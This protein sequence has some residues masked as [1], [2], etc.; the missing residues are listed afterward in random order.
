MNAMFC[1][2]SKGVA[3]MKQ[4]CHILLHGAQDVRL[5]AVDA[6]CMLLDVS[7]VSKYAARIH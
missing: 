3:A 5:Y 4:I 1:S 2:G 7:L 6:M